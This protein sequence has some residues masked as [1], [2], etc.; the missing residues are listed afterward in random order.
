M[1]WGLMVVDVVV[2]GEVKGGC[3][4]L[5]PGAFSCCFTAVF[6]FCCALLLNREQGAVLPS[7][8]AAVWW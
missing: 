6:Q 3:L 7:C 5:F 8:F 1:V 2:L 4:L